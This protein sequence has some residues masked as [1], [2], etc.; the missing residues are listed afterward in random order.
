MEE[1]SS[2]KE[3][4]KLFLNEEHVSKSE[5]ARIIGVSSGYVG[6]MR[7]SMPAEKIRRILEHF[8]NLNRD[9]LLYGEGPMYKDDTVQEEEKNCDA[10]ESGGASLVPLIPVGASAGRFSM[11]SEGIELRDCRRITSPFPDAECA[12]QVEGD[13]MEPEIRNGTYLFLKKINSNAFI[14]WGHP[15][16]LDTENGP[17]VKVLYPGKEDPDCIEA[18]SYNKDYPPLQVPKYSIYN[19]YRIVGSYR[20]G[21]TY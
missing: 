11:L 17:L 5:F 9:W 19:I 18:I 10:K 8:P 15:M 12:I 16:V 6:S 3:R 4:L 2:F 14:P 7:K 21:R 13:S 1:N 20:H